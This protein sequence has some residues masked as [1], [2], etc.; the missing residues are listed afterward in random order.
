MKQTPDFSQLLKSIIERSNIPIVTEEDANAF[1]SSKSHAVLF[2]AG[3]WE[4]LSE[5][6]DVAVILPELH[7]FAKGIAVAV[8]A[9]S[10]ERQLQLRYRFNKFP[11]LVFMR[12]TGYLGSILGMRGWSEYGD[13]IS[14]ILAREV[15]DP[16]PYRFPEGCIPA[17]A[18]NSE[19]TPLH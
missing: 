5:S 7:Q 11:A 10:A 14:E 2:F 13:Q 18:A 4:R 17:A 6:N 8:V 3:D 9:R 12:S 19:L 1:L 15:S 16:P